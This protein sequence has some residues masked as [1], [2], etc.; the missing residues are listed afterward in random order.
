MADE[1]W[2]TTVL[3]TKLSPRDLVTQSLASLTMRPSRTAMT[4]LG[5]VLG[6][7]AF[8]AV[9]GLTAT[10][11]GQISS[12]FSILRASEVEVRDASDP[13]ADGTV[14]SFPDDADN[15]I[16]KLNGVR[17]AGRT[18]AIPG[19]P[20]DVTLS[21]D[22][23]ALTVPLGIYAA[24]PGYL[25]ALRP[26]LSSGTSINKFQQKSAARVA[27]L[28][29]GAATQLGIST[30]TLHPIV[31]IHGSIYTVIGII[32][33]VERQ[34][35]AL[36]DI[37]IPDTTAKAAY[38]LPD[39]DS[40]ATMLIDTSLGAAALI[41]G[42]APVALRPDEPDQLQ[43]IPPPPALAV[44]GDVF[45]ALNPI[46]L[47]LAGLT[48]LIGAI[49]IANTTLVAVVERTREIGLRRSLG[50][51]PRDIGTQILTEATLTGMLGGL[52]GSAL[53]VTVVL[54]V[55]LGN[56]WT[57]ILDPRYTVLAPVVG[58]VAGVLAGFYPAR[59][60]ARIP[61]VDALRR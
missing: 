44:E 17:H 30:T 18:W 33:N 9:L 37:F 3:Q 15:L 16:E 25:A 59:R 2:R 32:A 28:G 11:S 54:V 42:Q 41:A 48:L 60:A 12:S 21:L 36:N 35:G 61:P 20:S 14:Y 49:G 40:R 46:F 8:V 45:G 23:R 26:T 10:A 19:G 51:R 53:A 29:I 39:A 7:G 31:V 38:G 55:A 6:V 52:L 47:A 56:S 27:V 13:A 43:A 24:S 34:P 57:A 58:A 22:P 1:R 4:M 50:A 5:T